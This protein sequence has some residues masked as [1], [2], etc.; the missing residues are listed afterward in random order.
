MENRAVWSGLLKRTPDD[1]GPQGTPGESGAHDSVP[2]WFLRRPEQEHVLVDAP[3]SHPG[4]F[5]QSIATNAHLAGLKLSRVHDPG[6][7]LACGDSG[8]FFEVRDIVSIAFPDMCAVQACGYV[9]G[10]SATCPDA[11][12]Y[13]DW[14]ECPFTQ[15]CGLSPEAH[16]KLLTDKQYRKTFT[17][18]SGGSNVGFLDG[19]AKW[20]SSD[21]LLTH[22]KPF[23]RRALE[24]ELCSCWPGNG[25]VPKGAGREAQHAQNTKLMQQI[26]QSLAARKHRA[27]PQGQPQGRPTGSPPGPSGAQQPQGQ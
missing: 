19:H 11:C 1:R 14:E 21:Y 26:H 18:H 16:A 5:R 12:N 17:R 7:Y 9:G 3:E 22:S 2:E 4:M 23:K 13:A 8:L 20:Y 6:K 27:H 15:A 24:G 10:D 25:K